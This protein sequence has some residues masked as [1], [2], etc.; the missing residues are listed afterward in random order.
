MRECLYDEAMRVY[1]IKASRKMRACAF[2]SVNWA[3]K[4]LFDQEILAEISCECKLCNNGPAH[5][6]PSFFILIIYRVMY[7][8]QIAVVSYKPT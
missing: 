3:P 1:G 6:I 2:L 5:V 8:R 7:L 4:G